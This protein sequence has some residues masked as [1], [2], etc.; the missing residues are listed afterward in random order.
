MSPTALVDV[1]GLIGAPRASGDEPGRRR[2]RQLIASKAEYP[3]IAEMTQPVEADDVDLG[4]SLES[5]IS[6]P[7]AAMAER[8]GR[9]VLDRVARKRRSGT[10]TVT[11]P[12]LDLEAGRWVE[13]SE[14]EAGCVAS[15]EATGERLWVQ[16]V[17]VDGLWA[18]EV[19]LGDPRRTVDQ[20]VAAR[21]RR[22]RR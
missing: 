5:S 8:V 10:A 4:S 22:A 11:G 12:V 18:A 9:Q 17:D 14:M 7:T 19:A 21:G 2:S 16:S 3:D 1:P 6:T 20:I 15:L 13:P